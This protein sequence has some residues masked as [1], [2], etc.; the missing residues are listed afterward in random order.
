MLAQSIPQPSNPAWFAESL[1]ACPVMAVFRGFSPAQTAEL[2]NAAWDIGVL[3]VEVPIESARAIASLEAA[4]AA[5]V[6]RGMRVGAGTIISASQ[7]STAI[8]AGAAYGVSPGL[9]PTLVTLASE[10]SFP[11]IPGVATASEVLHAQRLG[12]RWIK[13]FPASVLGNEWFIAMKGPFPETNFIATGGMTGRN[14]GLF[15]ASGASVVGV[16]GALGNA[17]EREM[18]SALIAA[19]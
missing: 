5:G 4:V 19:H 12:F 16:G 15:L 8:L 14:A 10:R 6:S 1:L 2:A 9:D 13:A 3:N 17:D 18:L 7:L 11:F